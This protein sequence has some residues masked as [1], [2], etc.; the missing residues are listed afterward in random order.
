MVSLTPQGANQGYRVGFFGTIALVGT[1]L[2]YLYGATW[3]SSPLK[4]TSFVILSGVAETWFFQIFLCAFIYRFTRQI[5]L[6][7]PISAGA[8]AAFHLARVANQSV[9]TDSTMYLVMFSMLIA[10][11]V[12]AFFSVGIHF[13]W[14]WRKTLLIDILSTVA[15][16]ISI[17]FISSFVGAGGGL[18]YLFVVF[19]VGM[20]LSYLTLLFRCGDGPAFGH[21]LVNALW[22]SG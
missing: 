3:E 1:V 6:A 14:N 12:L 10:G 9:S 19:L 5:F 17:Y 11:V 8:W 7:V 18:D 2:L 4:M 13:D 16:F 22:G 15:S 20:P 21:M